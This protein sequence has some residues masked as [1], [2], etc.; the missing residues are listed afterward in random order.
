[1]GYSYN[2]D[3]NAYRR[4]CYGTVLYFPNKS[5]TKVKSLSYPKILKALKLATT[6]LYKIFGSMSGI[7]RNKNVLRR[8]AIVQEIVNEHYEPG[9]QSKSQVQ[10][11]RNVLMKCYPMSERSLRRYMNTDVKEELAKL[12]DGQMKI[13]F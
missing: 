11:L 6:K 1:M 12:D 8:I 5:I 7:K 9:N 2:M 3:C 13:D 10:V 4:L